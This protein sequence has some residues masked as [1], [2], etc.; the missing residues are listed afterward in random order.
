MRTGRDGRY[1]FRTIKP[2][3]YPNR[4]DPA[5]IHLTVSGEGY[6]EYWIDSIWFEG[7]ERIKPEMVKRLSGRGGFNPIIKLERDANNVWRA[8]RNIKLENFK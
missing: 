2:G 8:A 5:H 7:D 3:G 1:E 6:P 4:T